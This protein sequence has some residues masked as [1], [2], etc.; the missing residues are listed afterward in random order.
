[1][2]CDEMFR[3]DVFLG[4]EIEYLREKFFR[5]YFGYIKFVLVKLGIE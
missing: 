4:L 2:N 5:R 1:M 3:F